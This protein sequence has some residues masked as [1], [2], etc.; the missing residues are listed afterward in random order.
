MMER[1]EKAVWKIWLHDVMLHI[2]ILTQLVS[3]HALLCR[4]KDKWWMWI[5]WSKRS[6]LKRWEAQGTR[7]KA[8]L[9]LK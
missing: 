6:S 7:R 5:W 8:V 1:R 9:S 4:R 2:T 3:V